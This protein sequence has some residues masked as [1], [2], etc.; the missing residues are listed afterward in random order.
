M[1]HGNPTWSFLY[2]K[3]VAE[4]RPTRRC[5]VP[6]HLGCGLSDKPQGA[7]YT[8]QAHTERSLA[9][10]N[11]LGLERFDLIVH[12]WG[13]AI[14]M[15][16]ARRVPEKI[17]RI[18][19]LNTAA[20]PSPHLPKRIALCRWPLVGTFLVRGLNGFVRAAGY[21]TTVRP[22][23]PEVRRAF[24]WPY[25]NWSNRRAIDAF[26]KDIPMSP[27]HP[28]YA[29]LQATAEALPQF[30]NHPILLAWGAK[31]WCFDTRFYERFAHLYPKAR[32]IL[33]PQAAHFPLEDAPQKLLP[34]IAEF[35]G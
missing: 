6:D 22:L 23:P 14:G 15:G 18:V 34:Q 8:L 12:D 4:L 21:M 11:A 30:A 27:Q 24:A 31:D 10:V 33:L 28:S 13:G 5:I 16:L 29:E 9:L 19:F 17:R 35:L 7:R 32:K 25:N 26:V 3:L 2:R 1:L 20:F